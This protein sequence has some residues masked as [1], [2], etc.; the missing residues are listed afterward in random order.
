M[1]M[2]KRSARY[3]GYDHLDPFGPCEMVSEAVILQRELLEICHQVLPE[4][5]RN[6]EA[7]MW[8]EPF[9]RHMC[10]QLRQTVYGR[11]EP[12]QVEVATYPADWWE[13]VKQRWAPLW[14]TRRWPVRMTTRT[15]TI[16]RG[17]TYPTL[18]VAGTP[19]TAVVQVLRQT[20]GVA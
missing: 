12:S 11:A 16:D 6:I 8:L 19:H 4:M 10:L 7:H 5:A 17:A 2:T 9:G 18:T 3:A 1:P 20:K 15:V 13:A 14:A